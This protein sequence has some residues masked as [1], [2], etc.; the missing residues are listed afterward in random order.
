MHNRQVSQDVTKYIFKKIYIFISMTA[1]P[2]SR[3]SLWM[4]SPDWRWTR[5]E[6]SQKHLSFTLSPQH[7]SDGLRLVWTDPGWIRTGVDQ[8]IFENKSP[9]KF[10]HPRVRGNDRRSSTRR[11]HS[12]GS[13]SLETKP[14]F[15]ERWIK[16]IT[17]I[18]TTCSCTSRTWKG[19][20]SGHSQSTVN[21]TPFDLKTLFSFFKH[22]S[23]Q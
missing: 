2:H 7:S 18:P 11:I 23:T 10:I 3:I 4:W 21:S 1:D 20:D 16:E 19:H 14:G 22:R 5:L 17:Y 15:P 6:F 12:S 9:R 8:N 13:E